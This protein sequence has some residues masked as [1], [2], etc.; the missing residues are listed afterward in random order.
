MALGPNRSPV[1]DDISAFMTSTAERGGIVSLATTTASGVA[2]DQSAMTVGYSATLSGVKPF[3]ILMCD[4]VNKDLSQTHLNFYKHEVQ[5]NSK[6]ELMRDGW[7]ETNMI[8]PGHTP[9]PGG[10]AYV[11]HSGYIAASNVATDDSD[12]TGANKVIGRFDT[13]KDEEGFCRVRVTL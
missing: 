5:V 13:A 6:V 2:L 10:K 7:V 8:Y 11:G 3:G 12:P 1:L 4:V 9:V